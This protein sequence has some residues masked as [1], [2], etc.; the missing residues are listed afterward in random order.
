MHISKLQISFF[1][2]VLILVL[3]L[4]FFIFQPFLKVLFLAVVFAVVF[5][6]LYKKFLSLFV[7]RGGASLSA[8]ITVMI[9]LM[10]ILIPSVGL[11]IL[12]FQE[13][14]TA[15]FNLLADTN[16]N[17][18]VSFL[19]N[20]S[21]SLNGIFPFDIVP[22]ISLESIRGYA[23]QIYGW[24]LGH[25][26]VLFTSA[27]N[28]AIGIFI[29]I[30]GLFFFLRDGEKFERVLI[31]LSPLSDE[32]DYSIAHKMK[33]AMNSVIKGSLF[34]AVL[35]GLLAGIGFFIF[36]VPSAILWGGVAVISAIIPSVG[37]ALVMIPA[38]LFLFFTSSTAS[39]VGLLIWA[40]VIVGLVDNVL[41]PYVLERGIKI[42]PFFILLSVLG[43]LSFFGP[44]GFLIGPVVLSLLFALIDIYPEITVPRK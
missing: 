8:F 43:G 33:L 38:V 25:F 31:S 35:Q 3:G 17:S 4:T 40:V 27:L 36:G 34:I 15:Y 32:Q 24:V 2:T 11:G 19:S 30:L 12:V 7:F 9:V 23:D 10:L 42:H 39:A 1:Y 26:Q 21:S 37:T 18:L 41:A 20:A 16:N 14:N 44:I 5:Y 13:M 22:D 6:P 29:M 28:L